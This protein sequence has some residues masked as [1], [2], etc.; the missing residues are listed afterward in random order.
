MQ[1]LIKVP[2]RY[3][4][5]AGLVGFGLLV[6]L[7]YMGRHP[8][9]IP[10]FL[11]FRIILFGVFIFF[12]LREIRDYYQNGILYFWQGIIASLL[13]TACFAF[14]AS[15]ALY[16]F[17]QAAPVFLSDYVNLSIQQLKSLPSP[18]IEKIGREVYE[19][20]LGLLP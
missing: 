9:L 18:V 5:I 2:L 7:Y 16:L 6:G 11:D 13:F 8:L 3:G 14:I 4:V 10:V 15:L 20:N 1:P 19:R 12:T 17:V